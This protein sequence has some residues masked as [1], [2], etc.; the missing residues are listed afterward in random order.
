MYQSQ[1]QQA[2][3]IDNLACQLKSVEEVGNLW[4]M[5]YVNH[6]DEYAAVAYIRPDVQYQCDF[7]VHLVPRVKVCSSHYECAPGLYRYVPTGPEIVEFLGI[8][9]CS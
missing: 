6:K 3:S 9:V 2:K 5:D 7:P 4:E 1:E 8:I